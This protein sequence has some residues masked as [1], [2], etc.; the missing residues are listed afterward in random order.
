M[1]IVLLCSE[2]LITTVSA[3]TSWLETNAGLIRPQL[4]LRF[5]TVPSLMN[6]NNLLLFWERFEKEITC[7]WSALLFNRQDSER[8]EYLKNL[9]QLVNNVITVSTNSDKLFNTHF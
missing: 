9:S 6:Y 2:L 7:S 4:W 8:T 1:L 3:A 5:Q